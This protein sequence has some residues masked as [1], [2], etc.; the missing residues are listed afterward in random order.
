MPRV[1][2]EASGQVLTRKRRRRNINL[3]VAKKRKIFSHNGAAPFHHDQLPGPR[4]IRLLRI[5]RRTRFG[6]HCCDIYN[7]SLDKLPCAYTAIS[8]TW[9]DPVLRRSFPC[10]DGRNIAITDSVACLLHYLTLE[11]DDFIIW[12]DA[13]CINQCDVSEKGHQIRLMRDI[14]ASATNVLVWLG[15]PSEDSSSSF[16][17]IRALANDFGYLRNSLR[18]GQIEASKLEKLPSNWLPMARLFCRPWFRR[19]WVLQEVA[20]AKE[21]VVA[22][23]RD[24][25]EWELITNSNR[26]IWE[27]GLMKY[28]Q[29]SGGTP[30]GMTNVYSMWRLRDDLISGNLRS[31]EDL[32]CLAPDFDATD[33]RDKVFAL[34]SAASDASD[35]AFN[36]D[37]SNSPEMIYI[38]AFKILALRSKHLHFLAIS[39][40]GFLRC[41]SHLPSWVPDLT[42]RPYSAPLGIVPG[43]S[44]SR[45]SNPQIRVLTYNRLAVSG[46]I[47]DTVDGQGLSFER[48]HSKYEYIAR[49]Q[50]FALQADLLEPYPTAESRYEVFWRTII[51]NRNGVQVPAPSTYGNYMQCYLSNSQSSSRNHHVYGKHDADCCRLYQDRFH[52]HLESAGAFTRRLCTTRSG[53]LGLTWRDT[54]KGDKVCI[55]LGSRIPFIIRENPIRE[56]QGRTYTLVGGCYIHGMMNGEGMKMGKVVEIVLA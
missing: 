6:K 45:T 54:T 17:Q 32:L 11:S 49:V 38:R 31:F 7:V 16:L 36:P 3:P 8:Y 24:R 56:D 43:Y 41:L 18:N 1:Q 46:I 26:L 29:I 19:I 48:G 10:V 14:Y 42:A 52:A 5:F 44:A 4:D 20:L 21:I 25:I 35:E 28:T 40:V 23:G 39:G 55:F 33:A 15:G 37:Y 51:S 47:V 30:L 2:S 9:G 34:L 22:C 27:A 13:I 12:I 50:E 53:Y